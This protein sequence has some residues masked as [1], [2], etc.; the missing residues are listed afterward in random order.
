[1]KMPEP[2]MPPMTTMVASKRPSR[3]A[4][5][6][7]AAGRRVARRYHARKSA[8][9]PR[10]FLKDA[11]G[12]ALLFAVYFV[13]ARLGL[14]LD[15]VGGFATLV[16]PPSGIALAALVLFGPRLWPGVF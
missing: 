16:W 8:G 6:V 9:M 11:L 4:S 3:G 7:S 12:S 13:T 5:A 2:T 10:G 15:A 14:R 1:M